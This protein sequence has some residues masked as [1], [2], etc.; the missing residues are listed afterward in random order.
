MIMSMGKGSI[1]ASSLQQKLN[2]WSSPEAELVGTDDA[3][4]MILWTRLF[5]DGQGYNVQDMKLY[6]DN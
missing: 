6:Q 1:Y 3:M 5:L 2:T 4:G